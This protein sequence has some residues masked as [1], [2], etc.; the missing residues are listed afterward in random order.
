[1]CL[2]GLLPDQ[3][4]GRSS[5]AF[6]ARNTDCVPWVSMRT[7]LLPLTLIAALACAGCAPSNAEPSSTEA[8]ATTSAALVWST[9]WLA[10]HLN[11]PN[12]VV[13]H[14]DRDRTAYDQGHIPGA[15]FLP[16]DAV[17]IEKEVPNELPPLAALE[18]AFED[19]GVSDASR[20]VLYG[21]MGG[22]APARAFFALDVLGL[23]QRAA[24]LDG[25]FD[26]WRSEGHPVSEEAPEPRRGSL[27][28]KPQPERVVDADSLW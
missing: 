28:P 8:V 19:V 27:T 7:A 6:S 16:V 25:S 23:G 3:D 10:A 11:D 9:A 1:M 21:G 24:M 13:I 18:A 20:V 5:A 14:V 12:L 15:R 22:L 17:A 4:P 26:L 2:L